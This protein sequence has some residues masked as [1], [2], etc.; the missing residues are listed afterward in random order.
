MHRDEYAGQLN[1]RWEGIVR[2]AKEGTTDREAGLMVW[3]LTVHDPSGDSVLKSFR[4]VFGFASDG[5]DVAQVQ[6]VAQLL[7]RV[8]TAEIPPGWSLLEQAR[9]RYM[10]EEAMRQY[11]AL[12]QVDEQTA[13][14]RFAAA[15]AADG[16]TDAEQEE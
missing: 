1:K 7:Q 13:W 6:R 5:T 15:D 11:C 2:E 10:R 8:V 4:S 3:L 9:S 12:E 14:K 16:G